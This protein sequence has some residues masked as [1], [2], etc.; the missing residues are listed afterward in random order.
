MEGLQKIINIKAAMNKGLSN[1]L[2]SNF[3][4][5]NIVDR[6]LIL[7]KNIVDNNWIAGFVSGEGN[8]DIYIHNSK[9]HKTGYQVQLRF[10]VSQNERDIQLMELLKKYLG[11]GTIEINTKTSV[12]MLTITKISII[13]KI[14]IP[15]FNKYPLL[16]VKYLDYLD[17]CKIANLMS[18][19]KHLT[20][21]GLKLIKEIKYGMN[22]C[23]WE[24]PTAEQSKGTDRKF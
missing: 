4:N 19:G 21:K 2:K 23:R 12:L 15:L 3:F 10:R 5:V 6:P 22:S 16:G 13:T 14:I 7:T 20:N 1:E 18:E 9:S 24:A 17:W 11:S 8:F